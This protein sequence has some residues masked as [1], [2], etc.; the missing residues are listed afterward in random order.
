VR[1]G[2][3]LTAK[4]E[5]KQRKAAYKSQV[6]SRTLDWRLESL[7]TKH[8]R[9]SA[10]ALG[11]VVCVIFINELV[12]IDWKASLLGEEERFDEIVLT[13]RVC[14]LAST[15]A[16]EL[17]LID[18]HRCACA[19]LLS[20]ADTGRADTGHMRARAR[21]YTDTLPRSGCPSPPAFPMRVRI[22][23]PP[24]PPPPPGSSSRLPSPCSAG[25]SSRETT[26]A[27]C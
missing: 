1:K 15:L 21:T 9:I 19:P 17:L 26:S 2:N 8:D 4:R 22:P 5:A 20:R 18:Y 27:L 24:L 25:P 16:L 13:L 7:K 6:T 14:L 11:G 10:L 3:T 23:F 12:Y